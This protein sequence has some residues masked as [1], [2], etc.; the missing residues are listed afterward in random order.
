[1]VGLQLGMNL[2]AHL[3]LSGYYRIQDVTYEK[4]CITGSC[5]NN[6]IMLTPLSSGAGTDQPSPDGNEA[7]LHFDFG[8]DSTV[9]TWGIKTGFAMGAWYEYGDKSLGSDF[10][11]H[12][13]GGGFREQLRFFEEHNLILRAGFAWA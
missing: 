3:H 6:N 12:K 10:T 2:P 1:G 9:N 5:S 13:F 4:A 7:Y 8:Y 11:Y